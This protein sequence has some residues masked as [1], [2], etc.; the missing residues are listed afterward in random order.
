MARDRVACARLCCAALP[1]RLDGLRD[2][3]QGHGTPVRLWSSEIEQR[4]R[5]LSW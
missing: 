3:E 5:G 1:V 2:E 4:E